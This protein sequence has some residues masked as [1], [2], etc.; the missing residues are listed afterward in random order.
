MNRS[1]ALRL[2]AAAALTGPALLPGGAGTAPAAPV[3]PGGLSCR[4]RG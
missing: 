3:R 2:R 4:A 1:S